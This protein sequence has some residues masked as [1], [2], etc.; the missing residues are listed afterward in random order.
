MQFPLAHLTGLLSHS[1]EQRVQIL[2]AWI[3]FLLMQSKN[4]LGNGREAKTQSRRAERRLLSLAANKQQHSRGPRPIPTLIWGPIS[5][6]ST[7]PAQ[8]WP[9]PQCS[10]MRWQPEIHVHLGK[11]RGRRSTEV[12]SNTSSNFTEM[13]PSLQA[14]HQ[15]AILQNR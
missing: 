9:P 15:R 10:R 4:I 14:A 13:K 8:P 6:R 7:S 12:N 1:T 3:H 11:C 2:K 5:F